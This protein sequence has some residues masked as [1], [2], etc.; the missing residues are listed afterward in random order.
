MV[1]LEIVSPNVL[2]NPLK[3][4]I[5]VR[6]VINTSIVLV[7]INI[8]VYLFLFYFFIYNADLILFLEFDYIY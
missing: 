1:G 2:D 3:C 4:T 5:I 8:L 7:K 6:I